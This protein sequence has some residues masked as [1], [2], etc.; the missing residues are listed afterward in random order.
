[1][2][3]PLVSVLIPVYNAGQYLRPSIKSILNQ[4]YR[5]LE[6]I[7]VDDGSTDNCMESI[8]D[9]K[10]SRIRI[11]SQQNSGVSVARNRCLDELSGDFYASQDADD[12]SYP[13]RIERQVK[14]LIENPNVAAVFVG[15]D[16]IINGKVMAPHFSSKTVEQCRHDIDDFIM[17]GFPPSPMYR[18]SMVSDIRFELSL[19]VVEDIDY[20]LRVGERY[21]MMTLGECLYSYRVRLNS[22]SRIDPAGN[23][24]MIRKVIERACQRRGLDPAKYV[25]PP[26]SLSSRFAHRFQEAFVPFFMESVLDLRRIGQRWESL[27]TAITC[28]KLHPLDPYYYKPLCYFFGPFK[29]IDCYRKWKG[30]RRR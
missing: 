18:I 27:K 14:C 15:Y 3:N 4:T 16:L 26:V 25:S 9:I 12:I 10:D 30:S 11:L 5:N 2:T 1:M 7:I 21:P 29:L 22:T 23:Q 28:L 6:I 13:L 19:K 20:I 24:L 17:P 8:L